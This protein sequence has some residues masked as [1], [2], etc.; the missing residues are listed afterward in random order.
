MFRQTREIHRSNESG[1]GDDGWKPNQSWQR[2]KR[3]RLLSV[4]PLR[5]LRLSGRLSSGIEGGVWYRWRLF[6][7]EGR[8]EGAGA[9][10][11]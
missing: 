8:R 1:D 2:S 3:R 4:R 9:M 7:K 5:R 11:L 6:E 10:S